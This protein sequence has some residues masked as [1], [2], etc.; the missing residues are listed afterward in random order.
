MPDAI[1]VQDAGTSVPPENHSWLA[2][3]TQGTNGDSRVQGPPHTLRSAYHGPTGGPWEG[4][5]RPWLVRWEG[6][7]TGG[8]RSTVA[9]R[10]VRQ[11]CIPRA[12]TLQEQLDDALF[13]A[14]L[15][16]VARTGSAPPV[17]G[18]AA[19]FC[20]PTQRARA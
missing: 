9:T 2:G 3:G 20:A 12:D 11:A 13:A 16:A 19:T 8:T 15:D 18:D 17:Y 6:I 14:S 7:M 4:S 1:G 5:D 10:G